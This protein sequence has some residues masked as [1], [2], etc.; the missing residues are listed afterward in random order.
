MT[1]TPAL[2]QFP[3]GRLSMDSGDLFDVSNVSFTANSNK[4][5]VQTIRSRP[6][7]ITRGAHEHNLTF[8]API[9]ANGEE[10]DWLGLAVTDVNKQLR[11]KFPGRT[12]NFVGQVSEAK[13][14]STVDDATK[15]SI[16]MIGNI[17][18]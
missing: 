5:L 7:G 10:F 4:K 11:F 2:L 14:D 3:Q 12:I 17:T 6:A 18:A 15:A 9:S 1:T 13:Y 16:T 8:E